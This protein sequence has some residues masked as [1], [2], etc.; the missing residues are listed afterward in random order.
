[1]AHCV[2]NMLLMK[3]LYVH[4]TSVCISLVLPVGALVSYLHITSNEVG[5]IPVLLTDCSMHVYINFNINGTSVLV[6]HDRVGVYHEFLYS[7]YKIY[8]FLK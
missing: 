4:C 7:I 5:F 8:I 2:V 3:Y 6:A 1:M